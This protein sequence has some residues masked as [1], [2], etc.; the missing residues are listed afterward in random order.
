[1]YRIFFY[2]GRI[3]VNT[4]ILE[5]LLKSEESIYIAKLLGIYE[6]QSMTQ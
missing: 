4:V 1:M 5:K 2:F 6:H 3:I